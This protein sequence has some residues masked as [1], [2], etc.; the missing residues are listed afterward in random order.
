[1]RGLQLIKSNTVKKM[2]RFPVSGFKIN[3]GCAL[4]DRVP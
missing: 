3:G 1:M 4:Q 2:A